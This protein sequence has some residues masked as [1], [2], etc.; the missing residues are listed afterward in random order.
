MKFKCVFKCDDYNNIIINQHFCLILEFN[1][2]NSI[3]KITNSFNW[4]QII[5]IKNLRIAKEMLTLLK[6]VYWILFNSK[7][8]MTWSA[9]STKQISTQVLDSWAAEINFQLVNNWSI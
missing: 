2:T 3:S 9:K 4:S 7:E 1:H 8:N 6:W 5:P